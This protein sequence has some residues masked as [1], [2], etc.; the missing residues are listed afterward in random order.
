M[1]AARF[2][3]G[4]FLLSSGAGVSGGYGYF[5]SFRNQVGVSL[6]ASPSHS[7]TG[8]ANFPPPT[9]WT[10]CPESHSSYPSTNPSSHQGAVLSTSAMKD[11]SFPQ[12]FY[13]P[14]GDVHS[15]GLSSNVSPNSGIES[16]SISSYPTFTTADSYSDSMLSRS[17][18]SQI[19]L[20]SPYAYMSSP[21]ANFCRDLEEK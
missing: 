15:D 8:A 19:D 13:Q 2:F 14:S 11:N 9:I 3:T 18:N 12:D 1:S 17:P 7:L 5:E 21:L 4:I 10:R 16:M 20:V 6:E